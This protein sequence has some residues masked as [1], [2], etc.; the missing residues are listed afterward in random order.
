M[1]TRSPGHVPNGKARPEVKLPPAPCA[2]SE[3]VILE[4]VR[5]S[6]V[7]VNMHGDVVGEAGSLRSRSTAA[8]LGVFPSWRRH[9]AGSSLARFG[10]GFRCR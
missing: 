7:G 9:A 6:N 3:R 10:G 4:V 2:R 1:R 8:Y 5:C